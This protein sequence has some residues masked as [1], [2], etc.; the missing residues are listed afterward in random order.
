MGYWSIN[1]N[2]YDTAEE[3]E[4]ENLK[5]LNATKKARYYENLLIHTNFDTLA[6][7]KEQNEK[8]DNTIKLIIEDSKTGAINFDSFK[9]LF[10]IFD[11]ISESGAY[12]DSINDFAIALS[13]VKVVFHDEVQRNQYE[14]IKSKLKRYINTFFKEDLKKDK[15]K[16]IKEDY[17]ENDG[18]ER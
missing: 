18:D 3:A 6:D 14:L 9:I 13:I 16:I 8:L 4:Q 12:L 17:I 15:P 11:R 5:Y 2:K 1:G 10:N 7:S